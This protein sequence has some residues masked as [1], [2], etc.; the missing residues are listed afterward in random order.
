[1]QQYCCGKELGQV[2]SSEQQLVFLVGNHLV[3]ITGRVL[4]IDK[5]LGSYRIRLNLYCFTL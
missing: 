5:M 2:L 4:K 1:M 3:L